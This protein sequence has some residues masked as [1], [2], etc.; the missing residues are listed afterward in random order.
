[1][2]DKL[3]L[4]VGNS[5]SFCPIYL[6]LHAFI[7]ETQKQLLAGIAIVIGIPF[8]IWIYY[9]G[10]GLRARNPMTKMST[11]PQRIS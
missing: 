2:L 9:H 7:E 8:P 10:E 1:M 5:V 6:P 11:I 4:G 3:G